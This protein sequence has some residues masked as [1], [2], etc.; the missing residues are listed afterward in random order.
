MEETSTRVETC[1]DSSPLSFSGMPQASSMISIPRATSPSASE[2]T[3]P[4]SE[5]DQRGDLVAVRVQQFAVL[6]EKGGAPGQ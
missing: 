6:E 3:L 2:C 4:C 5:R 1:V